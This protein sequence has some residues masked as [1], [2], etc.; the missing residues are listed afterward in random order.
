[1]KGFAWFMVAASLLFVVCS[2]VLGMQAGDIS[3]YDRYEAAA[4][5][6]DDLHFTVQLLSVPY[7]L[8]SL[9]L[10]ALNLKAR[11]GVGIAGILISVVMLLWSLILSGG[12]S[13]DEVFPA[14]ILAGIVLAT[15]QFLLTRTPAPAAATASANLGTAPKAFCPNCGQQQTAGAKFCS[16]CGSQ[17]A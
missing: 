5:E 6:R 17:M 15:L 14:W 8:L 10:F 9:V 3:F 12:V 4:A 13:F 11:K 16:G 2:I 1:M 7:F